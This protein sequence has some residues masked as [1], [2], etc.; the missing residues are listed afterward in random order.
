M[1]DIFDKHLRSHEKV[2]EGLGMETILVGHRGDSIRSEIPV[3]THTL[4]LQVRAS[5]TANRINFLCPANPGIWQRN[6]VEVVSFLIIFLTRKQGQQF[7]EVV[8]ERW[9]IEKPR[10]IPGNNITQLMNTL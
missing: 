9:G 6:A 8:N 1:L 2:C 4:R 3:D 5:L 7:T 10:H